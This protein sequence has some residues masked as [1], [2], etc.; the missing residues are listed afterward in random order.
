[1]F[2]IKNRGSNR[3]IRDKLVE[4]EQ[5]IYQIGSFSRFFRDKVLDLGRLSLKRDKKKRDSA[6]SL[7]LSY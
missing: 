2:Q 6:K 1:M 5:V 7:F 3:I 4:N